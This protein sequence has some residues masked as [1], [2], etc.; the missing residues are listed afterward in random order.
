[1]RLRG[2]EERWLVTIVEAIYPADGT[3]RLPLGAR[4]V[5]VARLA[6]DVFAERL[7]ERARG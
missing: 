7:A 4:V 2:F 3:P 6:R 5:P 1:M